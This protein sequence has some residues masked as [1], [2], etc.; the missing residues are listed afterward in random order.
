NKIDI[1]LETGV[2]SVY[3]GNS[4]SANVRL[5]QWLALRSSRWARKKRQWHLARGLP[6]SAT[7]TRAE[8]SPRQAA[9][10]RQ[11]G[12][13]GRASPIYVEIA[14]SAQQPPPMS[15]SDEDEDHRTAS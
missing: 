14:L 5:T 1:R 13:F 12:P 6:T 8:R 10:V 11:E 9:L 4:E 7:S 2:K 15:D 3:Q